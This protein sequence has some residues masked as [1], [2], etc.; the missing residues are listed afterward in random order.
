MRDHDVDTFDFDPKLDSATSQLVFTLILT[1]PG[2]KTPNLASIVA[3][4]RTTECGCLDMR[5]SFQ[6]RVIIGGI[7]FCVRYKPHTIGHGSF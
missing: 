2:I 7:H 5:Q 6:N 1:W 4:F 3:E